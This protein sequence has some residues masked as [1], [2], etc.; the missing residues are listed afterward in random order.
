LQL[1]STPSLHSAG[2][3]SAPVTTQ[4]LPSGPPTSSPPRFREEGP[5]PKMKIT[6]T[7][8]SVFLIAAD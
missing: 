1:L 6:A 4:P 2:V 7:Q 8:G 5:Q 3:F